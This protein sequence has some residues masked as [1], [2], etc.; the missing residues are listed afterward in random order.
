MS[1]SE[2]HPLH[3]E[4]EP[5]A[6]GLVDLLLPLAK[7]W[8]T[9][10]TLPLAAGMAALLISF[11]IPP[12]F[13]AKT[14]FLPPQ[15]QQSAAASALASLGALSGL[16]G[17]AGGIKSPAD[18]YVSLLGSVTVQDR[19]IDRFGLMKVYDTKFRVDA[20]RDLQKNVRV[21]AG[22]KD[23]LITVEVDD[24]DPKRAAEM[25][26]AHVEELRRLTNILALSEAQ[27]RRMFFETQL[28][29]TKERLAQAQLMLQRTGIT[30]GALKAEPRA[31]AEGYAQLRA[32]ATAAE[33]RLR[34]LENSLSEATP[35]VQ[36]QR[37]IVA[38][39][40]SQ[41]AQ[42]EGTADM[43][44]DQDYVGKYREF[45]YQETL[46]DLFARQYELARVD[47]SREGALIQVVDPA[48]TPEKKSKPRRASIA[49][50]ATFGSM[51]LFVGWLLI[52]ENWRR[53]N[54]SPHA[55]EKLAL[56]K[57]SLGGS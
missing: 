57:S 22:R 55:R 17:A 50:G 25:A 1:T 16:A 11:A 41:V 4:T 8:K 38:A 32:Q 54:T 51:L 37:A 56:L 29:Q 43:E 18:Q 21:T 9:L 5:S 40:R 10:A 30:P 26:N 13:T 49:L 14:T 3:L 35:E 6:F 53:S 34:A 31:A 45:K 52:R 28:R 39:L 48:K 46:Y 42:L 7:S 36:Q 47:E 24:E 15:Q 44:G 20:Q 23:N 33:I 19:I 2:A 27:Q 12:T